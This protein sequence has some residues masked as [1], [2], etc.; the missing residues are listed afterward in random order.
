MSA[1]A[2]EHRLRINRIQNDDRMN[3]QGRKQGVWNYVLA[4]ELQGGSQ[5]VQAM[6]G[7]QLYLIRGDNNEVLALP[8]QGRGGDHFFSYLHTTYGLHEHEDYTRALYDVLRHYVIAHGTKAELRRF[9]RYCV[10]TQTA[11]MSSYDGRM[12]KCDGSEI[13]NVALGTDSVFFADDDGGKPCE[14]DCGPHGM[15]LDRLTDLNFAPTG[16]SGITPE[17]QK[18]A[19][20]VWIFAL[21]FPDLM[22]T[23]PLLLIEGVK[24]S[25]KTTTIAML[26]LILQGA[27]SRKVVRQNKEDDFGVLLLR[28]PICLLDNVDKYI[29]WIP[30]AVAAYATGGEWSGRKLFTDDEQL[31]IKPH[32]FIAV[33]TRN[34]ASFRRD[35]VADRCLI[36][37]LERRQSFT[38]DSQLHRGILDNRSAL[39]GE[40]LWYVNQIVAQLRAAEIQT[41]GESER[42]ADFA[43]LGRVVGRVLGWEENAVDDLLLAMQAERD[44]FINEEDPLI[45]LLRRWISYRTRTGN[46]NVGRSVNATQLHAELETLAQ[47]TNTLWKDS[48]RTLAQK[49]RST[50]IE[51][52]FHVESAVSAGHKIFQLWRHSDARLQVVPEPGEVIK[53]P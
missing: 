38:P 2:A 39:L 32:A 13:T 3:L 27:Q 16:L 19:L 25:G 8:R 52:E 41:H 31:V 34:P 11:Y 37:R 33:S 4:N 48:P 46:G 51:R 22:P 47:A 50:H 20:I 26:Q 30:D 23:K 42:M 15:L 14:P 18:R 10:E 1:T 29:D 35:D 24:G 5:F 49:L 40:Y 17:Q 28:S 53:L 6:P 21:A 9:T 44:A 36:L 12:Y 7:G 43:A 45:E